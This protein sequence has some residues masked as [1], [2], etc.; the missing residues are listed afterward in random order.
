MRKMLVA[1]CAAAVLAAPVTAQADPPPVRGHFVRAF[2]ILPSQPH[3]AY[4]S[5]AAGHGAKQCEVHLLKFTSVDLGTDGVSPITH[6]FYIRP[7]NATR[8]VAIAQATNHEP[9]ALITC[10]H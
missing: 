3:R 9:T 1:C 8:A 7:R 4:F 2:Q 6:I 5:V 10:T